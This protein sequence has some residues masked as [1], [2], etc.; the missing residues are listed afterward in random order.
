MRPSSER[1]CVGA[2]CA[3]VETFVP[4]PSERQSVRS[5]KER[6]KGKEGREEKS[7]QPSLELTS[8]NESP[9]LK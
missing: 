3:A 7:R 8:P 5:F 4:Q 2:A 9:P 6:R 1:R